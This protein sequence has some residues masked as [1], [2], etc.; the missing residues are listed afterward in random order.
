MLVLYAPCPHTRYPAIA[1]ARCPCVRGSPDRSATCDRLPL[2]NRPATCERLPILKLDLSLHR[3]KR[4]FERET[5]P[6]KSAIRVKPSECRGLR[7]CPKRLVS[8]RAAT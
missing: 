7:A 1:F 6:V 2:A 5:K 3:G 4:R 8:I